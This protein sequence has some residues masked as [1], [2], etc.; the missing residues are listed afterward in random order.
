MKLLSQRLSAAITPESCLSCC[1]LWQQSEAYPNRVMGSTV[2]LF[3]RVITQESWVSCSSV[4]PQRPRGGKRAA[5]SWCR[6][7]PEQRFSLLTVTWLRNAEQGGVTVHSNKGTFNTST[8]QLYCTCPVQAIVHII[9]YISIPPV[10]VNR[11]TDATLWISAHTL[12]IMLTKK[13]H[14][15]Y[16]LYLQWWHVTK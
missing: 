15:T 13:T 10:D 3:T 7:V 9:C 1:A 4:C 2:A 6:F 11:R 16:I 14:L 12:F 5:R 8:H